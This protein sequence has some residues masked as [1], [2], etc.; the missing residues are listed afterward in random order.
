MGNTKPAIRKAFVGLAR[1]FSD[2]T[3]RQNSVVSSIGSAGVKQTF[4]LWDRIYQ[5]ITDEDEE[6]RLLRAIDVS[7]LYFPKSCLK[8]KL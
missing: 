1:P 3:I 6:R 8:M 2:A 7:L 5:K 4:L